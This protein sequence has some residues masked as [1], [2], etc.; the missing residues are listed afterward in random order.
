M[1]FW[2]H[3]PNTNIKSRPN[4]LLT[5]FIAPA[6]PDPDTVC[7]IMECSALKVN[8]AIRMIV[9]V[10]SVKNMLVAG[11]IKSHLTTKA[12]SCYQSK[13]A[14][15]PPPL[16]SRRTVRGRLRFHYVCQMSLRNGSS[17]L[18]FCRYDVS[19]LKFCVWR[20]SLF[21]T[22]LLA[23]PHGWSSRV[24]VVE[25]GTCGHCSLSSISITDILIGSI[26]KGVE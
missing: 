19:N 21:G 15:V 18:H 10:N 16:S 7:T 14:T 1:N 9:W 20:L 4:T 11:A 5:P 2:K 24:S 25:P 26:D 3:L 17:A 8:R 22:Y 6:G 23:Q 12:N 13:E